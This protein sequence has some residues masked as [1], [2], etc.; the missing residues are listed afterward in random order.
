MKLEKLLLRIRV[1]RSEF[2]SAFKNRREG[3]IVL[4][5]VS[6]V[7]DKIEGFGNGV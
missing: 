4:R 1:L 2:E 5:P 7:I 3:L 6:E